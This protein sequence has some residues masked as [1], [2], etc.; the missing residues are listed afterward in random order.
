MKNKN[1]QIEKNLKEYGENSGRINWVSE[2][3]ALAAE[4]QR[5]NVISEL[6]GYARIGYK[7][8]KIYTGTLSSGCVNCGEG[9]WSCLFI[10]GRCN[11]G[12]F[13]CPAEQNEISV[14]TTNTLAFPSPKDYVDYVVK[15]GIK[16]VSISGGEPLITFDKTLSFLDAVKKKMGGG[17]YTWLYTNGVLTDGEKLR[18]LRDTGLDEVR[19]NIGAVDYDLEK[20]KSAVGIIPQVTVEIPAVPEDTEI[21]KGKIREMNEMGVKYLNLHQLRLTPYN[22]E[23][24][25][26]RKYTFLHGEKVTVLESE[27]AALDIVKFSVRDKMN[28]S[29]NYCSFVYKNRFQSA[30][31]RRRSAFLVKRGDEDVTEKGYIRKLWVSGGLGEISAQE[32]IFREKSPDE[33]KW[34]AVGGRLYFSAELLGNILP[35]KLRLF[36]SYSGTKISQSI[37]YLRPFFEVALNKGRKIV[38]EISDTT[39]E[40]E[41]NP[42]EISLI[43]SIT[44]DGDKGY[45][46]PTDSDKWRA[47]K[48]HE[49]I[50]SGL[51]DYF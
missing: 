10:N 16:G 9:A 31:A 2:E 19:F 40:V 48:E 47:V 15:T 32:K 51:Q 17:I 11:C 46:L 33:V 35:G 42:E 18:K 5:E 27:L 7:G 34:N 38:V 44:S 3:A 49:F 1:K 36:I 21:L 45:I 23:N 50:V 29:V 12:C 25:A 8:T 14:P 6:R 20:V 30:A 22:Y 26:G 28:I 37:T 24:F 13:Y 4:G 43:R 41:I 39:G